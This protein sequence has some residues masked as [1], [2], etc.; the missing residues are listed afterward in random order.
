M[1]IIFSLDKDLRILNEIFIDKEFICIEIGNGFD[2]VDML[3]DVQI[4]INFFL[5]LAVPHYVGCS[6]SNTRTKK[7]LNF[8]RT[9]L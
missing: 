4:A 8:I 9:F 5:L 2:S 6:K 3:K 1:P 7:V